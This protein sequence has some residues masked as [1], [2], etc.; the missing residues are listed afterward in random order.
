[1]C[2]PITI[3]KVKVEPEGEIWVQQAA[4]ISRI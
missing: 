2:D 4:L 3:P 1:M